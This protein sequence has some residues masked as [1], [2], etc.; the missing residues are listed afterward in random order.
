[1]IYS[2]IDFLPPSIEE[3][4][5]ITKEGIPLIGFSSKQNSNSL[6]AGRIMTDLSRISTEMSCGDLHS[7]SM[8]DS[9]FI[10]IPC[11]AND[12]IIFCKCPL[13][14][15]EKKIKKTCQVI[16][17]MFIKSTKNLDFNQWDGDV[18]LFDEFKKHLE[19]YFK[20]CNL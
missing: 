11:I 18:S 15:K 2:H 1:M 12:V 8:F 19:I 5:I 17:K 9:K 20:M 4:S 10:S 3:I 16:S 14:T 13:K 7:F 6:L